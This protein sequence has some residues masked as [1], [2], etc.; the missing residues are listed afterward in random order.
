[1]VGTFYSKARYWPALVLSL[2]AYCWVRK[3]EALMGM[4]IFAGILIAKV[5]VIFPAGKLHTTLPRIILPMIPIVLGLYLTSYPEHDPDWSPWS[6]SLHHWGLRIFPNDSDTWR[7]WSAIGTHILVVGIAFSKHTQTV[8]GHPILTWL[9]EISYAVY[10]LH[11]PLIRSFLVW[12]LFGLRVKPPASMPDE[13]GPVRTVL[14]PPGKFHMACALAVFFAVLVLVSKVWTLYIESWCAKATGWVEEKAFLSK[15]EVMD[16]PK[17]IIFD[18]DRYQNIATRNRYPSEA[19]EFCYIKCRCTNKAVKVDKPGI[20]YYL[21]GSMIEATYDFDAYPIDFSLTDTSNHRVHGDFSVS[22]LQLTNSVLLNHNTIERTRFT[23]FIIDRRS[24]PFPPQP[25][26]FLRKVAFVGSARNKPTCRSS[27]LPSTVQ[28]LLV[29]AKL[30]QITD[31]TKLCV[32]RFYG[33][34]RTA[35]LG[36]ICL[37]PDPNSRLLTFSPNLRSPLLH[38]AAFGSAEAF[39]HSVCWCTPEEKLRKTVVSSRLNG[40]SK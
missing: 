10:L 36:G 24:L 31:A 17:V 25:E 27:T 7:F 14:E 22:S 30:P 15:Q 34:S 16:Y 37:N 40:D 9:G 2:Y 12:M 1:M 19:T 21:P 32:H 18:P 26:V 23:I 38:P 11:G 13:S 39:C 35:N 6:Q 28:K 20:K 3:D 5:C 4:N 8:L 29:G 33:G